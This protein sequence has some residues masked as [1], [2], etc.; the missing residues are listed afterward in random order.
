[1]SKF[2]KVN[3]F[4]NTPN[5]E[6]TPVAVI[7]GRPMVSQWE[8]RGIDSL[9]DIGLNKS[10]ISKVNKFLDS[11][12]KRFNN[13]EEEQSSKEY[14][15]LILEEYSTGIK[16]FNFSLPTAIIAPDFDSGFNK[17]SGEKK[18]DKEELLMESNKINS[19]NNNIENSLIIKEVP[20]NN[21]E[22]NLEMPLNEETKDKD[23]SH[24]IRDNVRELFAKR[25]SS[26]IDE[27]ILYPE[28]DP[29]ELT[30]RQELL[31]EVVK[32]GFQIADLL[33]KAMEAITE[34]FLDHLHKEN[35][36]RALENPIYAEIESRR[37]SSGI[38]SGSKYVLFDDQYGL[39][40]EEIEIQ[41]KILNEV[42]RKPWWE[43]PLR[44]VSDS[45][46]SEFLY[47]GKYLYQRATRTWD[48]RELWSLDRALTKRLGEQLINLADTAHGW[49]GEE[50]GYPSVEDWNS[51]LYTHGKALRNYSLNKDELYFSS[52][53]G[54]ELKY[55]ELCNDARI[56]LAW[57]AENLELLWD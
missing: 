31:K 53:P 13:P 24:T 9:S 2:I 12:N 47:K 10:E 20:V 52:L 32:T 35:A 4:L 57:V 8:I 3:V 6:K 7:L 54:G 27:E 28:M 42:S 44:I 25:K 15:D 17:I 14:L 18:I 26:S 16:L 45:P 22:E 41:Y 37:V 39:G 1:M 19:T 48:D 36:K 50:N 23:F 40:M 11:M 34:P 38:E 5:G 49:P 43:K 55:Q 33:D 21:L 30:T 29:P 51:V 46:V 56:A